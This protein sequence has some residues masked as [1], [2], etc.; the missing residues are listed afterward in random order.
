MAALNVC[1][2]VTPW[3]A[4][5]KTLSSVA[6][7]TSAQQLIRGKFRLCRHCDRVSALRHAP[8]H[9]QHASRVQHCLPNGLGLYGDWTLLASDAQGGI[10]FV[11]HFV[12]RWAKFATFGQ[13]H[14]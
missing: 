13:A 3:F 10:H 11:L 12:T 4:L 8:W 5:H 2:V 1:Y 7:V 6:Q 9:V 14:P